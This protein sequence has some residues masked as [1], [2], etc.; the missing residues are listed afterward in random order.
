MDPNPPQSRLAQNQE[1]SQ[2]QGEIS[3]SSGAL[4]FDSVEHLIRHDAQLTEPPPALAERIKDSVN[5]EPPPTVEPWWK[6][7][8]RR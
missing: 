4:E 8:F 6:R 1:E 7:L 2:Q 5:A 3:S